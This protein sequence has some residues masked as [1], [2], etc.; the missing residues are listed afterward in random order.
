MKKA[1]KKLCAA[2]LAT[3]IC[4]G[5]IGIIPNAAEVSADTT[6]AKNIAVDINGSENRG[7]LKSPV[8]T[9]WTL[10][11]NASPATVTIDG[12][13]FTL[14]ASSGAFAK[15]ENKTLMS[16][17]EGKTPYLTCDGASLKEDGSN[18]VMKISECV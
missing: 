12:V 15:S 10:S 11:G 16:T 4:A 9:D 17:A 3:G 13:T 7:N 2:V 18:I 8:F 1:L 6:A 5:T 14:I